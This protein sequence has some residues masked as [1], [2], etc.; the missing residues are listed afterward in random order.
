MANPQIP[1]QMG[2]NL[3]SLDKSEEEIRKAEYQQDQIDELEEQLGLEDDSAEED[4]FLLLVNDLI[5]EYI[6]TKIINEFT[7]NGIRVAIAVGSFSSPHRQQ[8]QSLPFD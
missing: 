2:G 5:E 6:L 3:P 4:H 8:I 7:Q 1:M